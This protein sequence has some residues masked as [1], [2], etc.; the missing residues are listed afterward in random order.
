[1]QV[2][3]DGSPLEVKG[4]Q[5]KV[6]DKAPNANLVNSKG[7]TVA[8][9]D[10]FGKVT[11]LSVV[12]NVLTRTCELQT[13]QF[14]EVTSD[15]N[16]EY[17]TIGRNTV[18]EFNQWN[19]DNE[20]EVETLTD[21]TGDFG[22]AYGLDIELDGNDLLTRAV[23]VVDTEGIIQYVEIVDEVVNEPNY[24]AALEAAEKL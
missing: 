11:I 14:D 18:E 1:M 15:K 9:N 2:N 7:E 12:P 5:P 13:K 17:V 24:D 16:I 20:L 22:K 21:S 3:F 8:L 6:G 10:L 23:F 4:T 19:T